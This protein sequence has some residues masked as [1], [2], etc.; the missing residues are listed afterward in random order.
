VFF[1][2]VGEGIL[3]P[4]S[5]RPPFEPHQN[6]SSIRVPPHVSM[7]LELPANPDWQDIIHQ[8]VE[9]HHGWPTIS[10][11]FPAPLSPFNPNA[12]ADHV[13]SPV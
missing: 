9:H 1:N 8:P 4:R 5:K 7:Q 3:Q 2:L 10:F 6:F 12:Q 11:P 13:A